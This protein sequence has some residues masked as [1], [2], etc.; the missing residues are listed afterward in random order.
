MFC[1]NCGKKVLSSSKYCSHCGSYIKSSSNRKLQ[2]EES[3]QKNQKLEEDKD[4]AIQGEIVNHDI[5][6]KESLLE[7][8][9]E[10]GGCFLGFGVFALI[11]IG[12]V[13]LVVGGAKLFE[14]I[15]PVLENISSFI[16]G[17]VWLLVVISLVPRLRNFTGTGIILGTYI[18]GAIFWLLCFYVTYMLWGFL[19]IFIGII[20]FGLGVVVTAFLALLFD[21]QIMGAFYFLFIAIQ[22]LLLRYLGFWIIGKYKPQVKN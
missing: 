20:M 3:K 5:V 18:G 10:L 19:G 7:K 8:I 17:I 2:Q 14:V 12:F 22:I 13:L 9:K 16:W 6:S 1:A 21:G 11:I 4:F 15:Y